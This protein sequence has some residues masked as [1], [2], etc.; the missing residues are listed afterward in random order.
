VQKWSRPTDAAL[1]PKPFGFCTFENG[2]GG[3]RCKNVLPN[4]TD[5]SKY[6]PD[7]NEPFQVKAGTKEQAVLE[8]IVQ[9]N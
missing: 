3:L 8:S 4:V 2:I 6:I 7:A 9:V 5:L 1:L